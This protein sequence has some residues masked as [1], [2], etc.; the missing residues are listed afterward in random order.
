MTSKPSALRDLKIETILAHQMGDIYSWKKPEIVQ[1]IGPYFPDAFDG[2]TDQ[3]EN[4]RF[5]LTEELA[6]MNEDTIALS[7]NMQGEASMGLLS[8]ASDWGARFQRDISA[9]NLSMP[10]WFSCGLGHPEFRADVVYWSKMRHFELDEILLLS[11]GVDPRKA[12]VTDMIN[13]CDSDSRTEWDIVGFVA[14]RSRQFSRQFNPDTLK[15]MKIFP[16]DFID[17]VEHVDLEVEEGFLSA[18]RKIHIASAPKVSETKALSGQERQSL[19][20]LIAA[21]SCEQYGFN[22]N[23]VRSET[24]KNIRTDVEMIGQSMDDKTIRKWLDEAT[25]F[26]DADYWSEN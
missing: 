20:K 10:V 23:E 21:M 1:T 12:N 17:F 8:Q 26:V 18:L 4:I 15:G 3:V 7:F 22:P 5:R 2:Y 11:M 13:A 25:K 19:L 24:T 9:L 6:A 14:D 16:Q